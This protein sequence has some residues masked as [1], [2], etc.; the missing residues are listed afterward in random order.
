[1]VQASELRSLRVWGLGG[2]V[3]YDSDDRL[4]GTWQDVGSMLE[5][6][7]AGRT[8]GHLETAPS[9]EDAKSVEALLEVYVPLRTGTPPVVVG[10]VALTSRQQTPPTIAEFAPQAVAQIKQTLD[11]QGLTETRQAAAEQ[12]PSPSPSPS[13][14]PGET[15]GPSAEA[16][17]PPIECPT[18]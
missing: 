4:E 1:M 16:S 14:A 2:R 3:L 6:A 13:A 12:E 8:S 5:D 9:E 15:A 17:P 11:E 18:T 7:Y 10:A